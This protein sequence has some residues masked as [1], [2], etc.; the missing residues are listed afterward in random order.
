MTPNRQNDFFLI[1][2]IA[3]VH[4]TKIET[5][6]VVTDDGWDHTEVGAF[7]VVLI[8][9]SLLW[10][11]AGAASEK[12]YPFVL[13]PALLQG[14]ADAEG[15]WS[16]L[17]AKLP[18]KLNDSR[19]LNC[20]ELIGLLLGHDSHKA[21]TRLGENIQAILAALQEGKAVVLRC[22]CGMHQ[23]Q[24]CLKDIYEHSW[25]RILTYI[26]NIYIM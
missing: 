23:L 24:I 2:K 19:F 20:A 13:A 26:Y 18:F 11:E 6:T 25:F 9:A 7:A 10:K 12:E 22:R 4:H 3:P 16:A 8:K 1:C 14:A 5:S 17:Q 15:L 21:N